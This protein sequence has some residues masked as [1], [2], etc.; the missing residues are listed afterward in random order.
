MKRFAIII[1]APILMLSL[2]A[3]GPSQEELDATA[4]SEMASIQAQQTTDAPT[5]VP[6]PT[7]TPTPEPTDTPEPT[8]TPA[9]PQADELLASAMAALEG[10]PSYHMV[11]DMLATVSFSGMSLDMSMT[12]DGDVVDTDNLQGTYTMDLLG[13]IT[14]FEMIL[15]GEE[16]YMRESGSDNWV[17]IPSEEAAVSADSFPAFDIQNLT[18]LEFVGEETL[19]GELVYHVRGKTADLADIMSALNLS[20]L[21]DLGANVSISGEL[22]SEYW[23]GL[24]DGFTRKA[25]VAGDMVMG[26]DIEGLADNEMTMSLDMTMTYSDFGK[27]V[28]IQAPEVET[29]AVIATPDCLNED[30]LCIGL[31]TKIGGLYDYNYNQSSWEGVVAAGRELDATVDFI[32][33]VNPDNYEANVRQFAEANYDIIVTVGFELA[34]AT[35]NLAGEYPDTHFIAVDQEHATEFDNLTGIIFEEYNGGFLAGALAGYLTESNL[36]AGVYGSEYIPA[37][38]D[39]KEG[40]EAGAQ[41]TNPAVEVTSTFHP[42]GLEIAFTDP[43]WGAEIAREAIEAGADVIFGAGGRTGIGALEEAVTHPFVL[44]VGVDSD[45]WFTNLVIQPC[46]VSSAIKDISTGV[47]EA[48]L[49]IVAGQMPGGNYFGPM[50][51]A[52]Y[53][54]YEDEFSQEIRDALAELEEAMVSGQRFVPGQ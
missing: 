38:V 37:V 30:I 29:Q 6:T 40:F 20:E 21:E 15:L 23:I 31:V 10:A 1:L 26:G 51:L 42:G 53:H 25:R 7:S 39:F 35:H 48:I 12:F 5:V 45:Q 27:E 36:V 28:V 34:E 18:D 49:L 8:P 54:D 4:T 47:E 11:M 24:E 2:F 19:D 41:Y 14:S 3:C 13:Q 50:T 16:A 17:A 32:E 52:P 33:T 44:C 46:L 43:E 9:L 22:D